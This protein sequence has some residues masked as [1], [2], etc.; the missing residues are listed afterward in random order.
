[1]MSIYVT[2]LLV[3]RGMDFSNPFTRRPVIFPAIQAGRTVASAP[4][5]AMTSSLE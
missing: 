2:Y 4:P 3:P 1:M 5:Q